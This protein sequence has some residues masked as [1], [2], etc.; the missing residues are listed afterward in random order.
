MMLVKLDV[1][2]IKQEKMISTTRFNESVDINFIKIAE[3]SEVDFNK[4]PEV[5]ADG[6]IVKII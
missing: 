3:N 4:K 5:Q 1:K 2:E 6:K